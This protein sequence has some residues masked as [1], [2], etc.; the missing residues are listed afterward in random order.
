MVSVIERIANAR[1]KTVNTDNVTG[2]S[3]YKEEQYD[4][5]AQVLRESLDI[6]HIYRMMG[7]KE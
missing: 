4:R 6:D 1:G 7:I 3:L 2:Y 5:L